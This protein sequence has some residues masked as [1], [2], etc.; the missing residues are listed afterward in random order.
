MTSA[1]A[2]SRRAGPSGVRWRILALIF[3]ASFVAYLLRTNMSVAGERMTADLG[4]TQ[5]Q[6]GA[7]LAAFAWGY[8]AAQFPSGVWGGRVGARRALALAALAWGALNLLVGLVPGRGSASPV[9]IMAVLVSLRALMGIAQAPLYPVTGGAMTCDWF[10]VTGWALPNSLGNAGLTLGAAATGPI[11]ASLMT[12]FGWRLSFVLTAPLALLLAAVWWWYT[13]DT[14]AQHPDVA[15]G[16]LALIE[17]DRPPCFRGAPP[18]GA[19]W[20]LLRDPQVLLLTIS[21]FCSNYVFYFFFNW[22]FIY[23]VENRGFK[24]LE[25]GYYAAIPWIVGAVGAVA[26]GGAC[27][28]LSASMGKRRSHR[29]V[30]ILGLLASGALLLAAAL[31][32]A[33]VTAVV[34]L[35]LCLAFQ[36]MTD[37]VY[38]SAGISVSGRHAAAATG[39]MNTGGNAVGGVGALLV[40]LTVRSLGWPAALATGAGFAAVGALLWLRI[41]A[42]REFPGDSAKSPGPG[43]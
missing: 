43:I 21:Y 3:A 7:V 16:E 6:L 34:L 39:V 35:S 32:A 10:P 22:L 28:R 30:A 14:P 40:P 12:A 31:A 19:A 42:D 36:Q 8:A 37:A 27:D 17:K 20:R 26:G 2:L 5:L 9:A 11:I 18:A 4:L 1:E 33:P 13:R 25:G 41:R 15:A 29:L 38:W 23:L 24:V